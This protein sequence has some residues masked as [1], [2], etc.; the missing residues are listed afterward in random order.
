MHDWWSK[1]HLRRQ[2]QAR[3]LREIGVAPTDDAQIHAQ[4][5]TPENLHP[6]QRQQQLRW[7]YVT[8][9]SKDR[10]SGDPDAYIV[11]VTELQHIYRVTLHSVNVPVKVPLIGSKDHIFYFAEDDQ[12]MYCIDLSQLEGDSN[13]PLLVRLQN[14][15]NA[16]GQHAYVLTKDKFTNRVTIQQI[17]NATATATATSQSSTSFALLF[18]QTK[19]NCSTLLGFSRKNYTGSQQYTAT[20]PCVQL[21]HN[22]G[23]SAATIRIPQLSTY[24]IVK[25]STFPGMDERKQHEF[26]EEHLIFDAE[27]DQQRELCT[28]T[29][30]VMFTFDS[31]TASGTIGEHDLVFKCWYAHASDVNEKQAKNIDDTDDIDGDIDE[32]QHSKVHEPPRRDECV[33]TDSQPR[34]KESVTTSNKVTA[35]GRKRLPPMR[36]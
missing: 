8:I 22:G 21:D 6:P 34:S 4:D 12:P 14:E 7:K 33:M 26:T 23:E 10:T 25:L 16:V 9:S 19:D 1:P 13:A 36:L 27:N 15:M 17:S 3:Y 29:L 2:L 30:S 31:D 28:D 24:P 18:E 5:E 20:E 35:R 32:I 11:P